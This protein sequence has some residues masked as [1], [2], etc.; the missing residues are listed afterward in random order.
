M[1]VY[2]YNLYYISYPEG[3]EDWID[4]KDIEESITV[5]DRI[6]IHGCFY[7]NVGGRNHLPRKMYKNIHH[8]PL[9]FMIVSYHNHNIFFFLIHMKILIKANVES[10]NKH[11][12]F[13]IDE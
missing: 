11:Y 13:G 6:D 5:E 9:L 8:I 4:K 2:S 12:Y 3:E 7:N 10:M 1:S